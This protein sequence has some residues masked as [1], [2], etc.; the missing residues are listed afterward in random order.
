MELIESKD[1]FFLE[2]NLVSDGKIDYTCPHYYANKPVWNPTTK[3]FKVKRY[4]VL[5][6]NKELAEYIVN[7][8]LNMLTKV[9][10][11]YQN[12]VYLTA[13]VIKISVKE[14]Y[15]NLSNA[16][17]VTD[18]YTYYGEYDYKT[19]VLNTYEPK[20]VKRFGGI[21]IILPED[22]IEVTKMSKKDLE[23][24]N[25]LDKIR[26]DKQL[27]DGFFAPSIETICKKYNLTFNQKALRL[28]FD[29]IDTLYKMLLQH[30]NDTVIKELHEVGIECGF[31]KRNKSK[32]SIDKWDLSMYIRV[33]EIE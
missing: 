2:F 19:K 13:N 33:K 7:N 24:K 31:V 22:L 27:V 11:A 21:V 5:R 16:L 20:I 23:K 3:R 6:I 26:K 8:H 29:N 17:F 4:F 25:A 12:N 30:I 14:T 15:P 10:N 9:G 18:A 1:K 28:S 32:Q